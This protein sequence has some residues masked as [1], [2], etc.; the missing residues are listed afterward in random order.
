MYM[1]VYRVK[2]K[3]LSRHFYIKLKQ[4]IDTEKARIRDGVYLVDSHGLALSII[5][6]AEKY[7]ASEIRL[8][9]VDEIEGI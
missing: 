7:G 8:F 6:L 2:G 4:L 5:D 3:S 1:I 9:E